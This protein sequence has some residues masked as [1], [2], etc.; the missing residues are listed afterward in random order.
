[1]KKIGFAEQILPGTKGHDTL[2]GFLSKATF[3]RKLAFML[4]L[5]VK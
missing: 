4:W 1:L 2:E 5:D 3:K